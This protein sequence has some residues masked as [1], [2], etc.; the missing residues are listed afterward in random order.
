MKLKRTMLLL[1]ITAFF[2]LWQVPAAFA[3]N[4]QPVDE[5]KL[6]RIQVSQ[7]EFDFGRVAQGASISHVFWL[8]N[9]GA[10]TLRIQDV[11][12]G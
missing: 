5:A 6:P 9:V 10:D 11:K 1:A 3:Q 12:P 8:K 7:T 4:E 2:A